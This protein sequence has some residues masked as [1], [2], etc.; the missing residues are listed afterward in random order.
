[1]AGPRQQGR[2]AR[3][4]RCRVGEADGREVAG[5]LPF[6]FHGR[7][8]EEI[9]FAPVEREILHGKLYPIEEQGIR[10]MIV[11]VNRCDG[12]VQPER[13]TRYSKP[14]CCFD[15]VAQFSFGGIRAEPRIGGPMR[16]D[17]RQPSRRGPG[18]DS[19]PYRSAG[20][21]RNV[22]T[23]EDVERCIGAEYHGAIGE[24][25]SEHDLSVR[26][27]VK[28][29]SEDGRTRRRIFGIEIRLI[30]RFRRLDVR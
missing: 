18:F 16:R 19:H 5:T 2:G 30:D 4:L 21:D 12:P 23:G 24:Y 7:R 25:R 9:V 10:S 26:S 20:E 15:C 6:E 27:F 11:H 8:P 13:Q 22:L 29:V 1:M 3:F 14:T 28:T 17:L